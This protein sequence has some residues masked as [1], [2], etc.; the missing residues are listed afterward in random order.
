MVW[1]IRTS[2]GNES[3]KIRW[4]VVQYMRGSG[5]D[6]G[7][8]PWKISPH[9]VGVD[10]KN[11]INGTSGP[12]L[13]MNCITLP[14]F[15][16]GVF[17]FV[18]SSHLLEH[19]VDTEGTLREWLRVLSEDGYL[20][21]YLPHK[22]FYPNIGQPGANPDHKHDFL[23]QDIINIMRRLSAKVGLELIENE[24]RNGG[25]E[26]SFLQVYRKTAAPGFR[27]CTQPKAAKRA[28][29]VRPGVYGD[30]LWCSSIARQLKLE[31]FHV[32]VYTEPPGEEILRGD[33][34]IDRLVV[35][36]HAVVPVEAYGAYWAALDSTYDRWVNLVEVCEARLLVAPKQLI[37]GW[38]KEVRHAQCDHNY[39]EAMHQVAGVP[40][41][42]Q[43]RFYPTEEERAWA[44]RERQAFGRRPVVVFTPSGSTAPKFWPHSIELVELLAAR[45]V[46][47]VIVGD[48][49]GTKYPEL[50]YVHVKSMSEWS[51]RKSLAFAQLADAV[52]GQE[53]VLTNAV[54]VEPMRKVVLLSHS[55]AK[56]LT[57][58]WVNT[59]ALSG[60]AACYPC[61]KIHYTMASCTADTKTGAAQ[62]QATIP[63]A[64]VLEALAPAIE[65]SQCVEAAA[66]LAA[67][68]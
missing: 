43:V 47:V 45:K 2:R 53:S 65:R 20:I 56:N 30:S 34:H 4:H 40:Y 19:I 42:L 55:S 14:I 60:E 54:C 62:C 52:V 6:I 48:T 49:R 37:Y 21:L 13:V 27:D 11:Y 3:A 7:C 10:G 66:E 68:D 8:G 15:G 33:P 38:P 41:E 35:T 18:Y 64:R 46:H 1:D 44:A 50:P 51:L 31:G 5:L 36:D 67:A 24:E 16:D 23:P 28:A 32:T 9:A 39:L 26:Y 12:N 17:D 59:V 58:D 29:I 22:L 57:R 61:H 63:A 25:D